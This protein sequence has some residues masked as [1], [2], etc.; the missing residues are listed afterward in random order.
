MEPEDEQDRASRAE[1]LHRFSAELEHAA[2]ALENAR[3][4]AEV[5]GAG[6]DLRAVLEA[7]D[8]GILMVDQ[9]LRVRYVNRR[10]SELF[11]LDL[12]GVVG[13]DQRVILGRIRERLAD[14]EA[15][16]RRLSYLYE[17]P[18]EESRDEVELVGSPSPTLLRYSG[19]VYRKN[20][21]LVGRIEAHCDIT[22]RRRLERAKADFMAQVVHELRSPLTILRGHVQLAQKALQHGDPARAAASLE[23][24]L[25]G[26]DQA[27]HLVE[28]L[29][30]RSR[31]DRG[32]FSVQLGPC[33]LVQLAAGMLDRMRAGVP[34][35][36]ALRAEEPVVGEW[37]GRRLEQV[38]LNLISNAVKYSPDGGDVVVTV[39]VDGREARITVADQGIGIPEEQQ[40]RLFEPYYRAPD[41]SARG[42][43]GLGLGLSVCKAIVDAHG[44][45][46]WVES[47]PGKGSRFVVALPVAPA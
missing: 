29:Q 22:E 9:A 21:E 41:A 43:G 10:M 44:G 2:A 27:G 17:H 25:W 38:L 42:I 20:G 15:F 18:E 46:I 32:R 24:A 4:Y 13:M 36:L 30:D 23:K 31:I 11:G 45:R 16:E 7:T 33:D 8:D 47:K 28:M 14:P 39:A 12:S 37:D 26:T 19:P 5:E 3:L 34:H 35:G 40:D 1:E 6:D